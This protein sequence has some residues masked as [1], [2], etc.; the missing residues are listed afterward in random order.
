MKNNNGGERTAAD[1]REYIK[2]M[3]NGSD[4]PITAA[5]MCIRDSHFRRS[6]HR[7]SREHPCFFL[8]HAVFNSR[9]YERF[10]VHVGIGRAASTHTYDAI[11]QAFFLSLIHIF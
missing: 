10:D 2:K 8:V 11:D 6:Q 1:R 4:G 7:L 9:A 5:K 3:L